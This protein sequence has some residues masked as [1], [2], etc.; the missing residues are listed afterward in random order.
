ML[1]SISVIILMSTF[2]ISGCSTLADAQ[3]AKGQGTTK[4]YEK[5]FDTVWQS[6]KEVVT[7]SK[8]D[9]VSANK[10][11]GKIL[12]QRSMTAFS[13]GEN[14]AIFVE[15]IQR[16]TKT[17]VEIVNKKTVAAN[18]TAANWEVALFRALDQKLK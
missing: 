3:A 15:P 17:R 4:V 12:A 11:E 6:T 18:L 1:R 2:L 9:L 14:V 5:D 7:S 16:N 13:Y 10:T 8:L